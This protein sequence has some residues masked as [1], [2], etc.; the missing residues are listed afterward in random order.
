MTNEI[1]SLGTPRLF[2]IYKDFTTNGVALIL[3]VVAEKTAIKN[4]Y[5]K[6]CS[7]TQKGVI[8]SGYVQMADNMLSYKKSHFYLVQG[9]HT[10]FP[11]H[12]R[13]Q[14]NYLITA[15]RE[16]KYLEM[17]IIQI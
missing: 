5:T 1:Y 11:K 4:C 14:V 12:I 13:K 6:T 3:S 8:Q 15:H 17:I 2:N 10:M 7:K 9:I 16:M